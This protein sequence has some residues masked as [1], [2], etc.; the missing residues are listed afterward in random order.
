MGFGEDMRA[1]F[2]RGDT[3]KVKLLSSEELARA[4]SVGD[5]A[6]EV[7][8]LHGL[9]AAAMRAEDA[10][11][12]RGLGKQ[13]LAAAKR[14]GDKRLER[15]AR[16]IL[17]GAARLAGNA[18]AARIQ[19]QKSIALGEHAGGEAVVVSE[20]HNLGWVELQAGQIER[21]RELFDSVRA[22]AVRNNADEFLPLVALNASAVAAAD[23]DLR[24][25]AR[26]LA[27]FETTMGGRLPDPDD[28]KDARSLRNRLIE[29]LEGEVFDAEYAAGTLLVPLEVLSGL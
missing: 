8:A 11:A 19:Y 20:Q 23:G 1:A 25:A 12:A 18:P 10:T 4:R 27:V 17:A 21:A 13:A 22:F 24:Q 15:D 5:V 9:A 16:H 7:H 3:E 29:Q 2:V 26:L 28:A 6:G 14:S